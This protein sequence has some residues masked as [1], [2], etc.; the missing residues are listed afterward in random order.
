M[1]EFTKEDYEKYSG[2]FKMNKDEAF[3]DLL[4]QIKCGYIDVSEHSYDEIVF[5]VAKECIEKQIPMKVSQSKYRNDYDWF[6]NK[7]DAGYQYIRYT[8][9]KPLYCAFCGQKLDWSD[10]NE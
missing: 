5:N 9:T 4:G 8:K 1:I 2:K 7:C 6:C 10:D 3:Q